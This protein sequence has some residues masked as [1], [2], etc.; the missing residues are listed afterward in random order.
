[1]FDLTLKTAKVI[2][3]ED[4]DKQGKIQIQIE[5]EM[6]NYKSNLYPWAIPLFSNVSE[7]TMNM[8]LPSVNSQVWIL[9]DKYYKRFYYLSNRYFYNL[10]DF[11]KVS[12][13]LN[14]CD[15]INKDY[16]NLVFRYFKDKTLLFHNNEDGSS[17]II[18]KHGTVIYINEDGDLVKNIKNDEVI[19]IE[20]NKS[21]TIKK[22]NELSIKGDNDVSINGKNTISSKSLDYSA[23]GSIS[24]KSKSIELIELGNN[25]STLGKIL[26]EICTNLSTLKVT[27]IT[28]YP[29]EP[30]ALVSPDLAIQMSTLIPKIQ[31]T[32]K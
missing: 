10:F 30:I 8:D 21:E 14:K 27:G 4:K 23:T 1:M 7:N 25:V 26:N 5:S 13:L 9:V 17:G 19:E 12:G 20:G 28:P 29:S 18:T 32:F 6:K 24:I 15:K 31:R 16:E 11:S 22:D 3:I 2:S